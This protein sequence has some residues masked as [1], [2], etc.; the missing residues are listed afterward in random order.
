[1]S[2]LVI[3]DRKLIVPGEIIPVRAPLILKRSFGEDEFQRWFQ[4]DEYGEWFALVCAAADWRARAEWVWRA[5]LA[6]ALERDPT[7]AAHRDSPGLDPP[8]APGTLQGRPFIQSGAGT[9]AA[10]SFPATGTFTLVPGTSA[11]RAR[12]WGPGGGGAGNTNGSGQNAGAGGGGGFSETVPGV[13]LAATYPIVIGLGGQGGAPSGNGT[14]GTAATTGFGMTCNVGGAGVFG[15][16]GG[17]G[18]TATGGTIT[19]ATGGTGQNS[20]NH[21]GGNS[22][23]DAQAR[24]GVGGSIYGP[25]KGPGVGAGGGAADTGSPTAGGQSGADGLVI[26][27]WAA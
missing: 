13:P 25:I 24:A 1:M 16:S 18:G 7:Q 26:V 21:V 11:L 12:A 27:A 5:E 10:Q 3:R 2:K 15:G 20:G 22:G 9:P 19:N 23:A 14:A 8:W 6:D 17:S 4:G